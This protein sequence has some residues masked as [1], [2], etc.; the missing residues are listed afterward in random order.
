VAGIYIHIPFCKK[1]CTYCDFHFSTSLERKADMVAA[2]KT[3]IELQKNYLDETIETI[4]FG[5]G[6]PSVLLPQ[7]IESIIETIYKNFSV[8]LK[9]CTL[10]AN[11][12]DLSKHYLSELIKTSVNRL[13]I[14]IQ[15]FDDSVLKWMN[16]NHTA[17]TATTSV[18][19]AA[20]AGF[21]K[22]S[23][24]LIY[25]IP[26]TS[27]DDWKNNLNTALQLPIN[28]LSSYCL[29]AEKKTVYGNLIE[30]QKLKEVEQEDAEKQFFMLI[31]SANNHGFEQY[32]ISNFC[33][34]ENY[35]LHNT[36]YW[37]NKNYLGI[38]PSAHSYNG[39]S[40]QWNVKNNSLYIKALKNSQLNFEKEELTAIQK[41]NE[42]LMTSLR[43]KWGADIEKLK[44]QMDNL[45]F[46]E[47]EKNMNE[48]IH[49]NLLALNQTQLTIPAA[50]KFVAD[51]IIADL[52]L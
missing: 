15:S 28:H 1:A 47:F 32:E 5:G 29:T 6:T 43:T 8:S 14:G 3:E 25:A 24:D 11:P 27:I 45:Q 41:L 9:E 30:N 37:K 49:K 38:G 50:Q 31:E 51:K 34:N 42:Y 44:M 36:S 16:R 4:Y 7:E 18:I 2:I 48:A 33:K 10:E 46:G 26:N 40:R 52:F 13:S 22:I 23:I 39:M 21:K 35:A 19:N 12:D 17:E 20:E